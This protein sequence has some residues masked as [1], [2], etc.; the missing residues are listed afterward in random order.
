MDITVLAHAGKAR[1]I[2]DQKS[3]SFQV[4]EI[5]RAEGSRSSDFT[6]DRLAPGYT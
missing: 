4:A 6:H 1:W 5:H 3:G 2:L